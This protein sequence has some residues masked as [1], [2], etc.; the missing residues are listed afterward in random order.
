MIAR[1]QNL[2]RRQVSTTEAGIATVSNPFMI[3][4]NSS[5]SMMHGQVN[6]PNPSRMPGQLVAAVTG[7]NYLNGVVPPVRADSSNED[8]K[9]YPILWFLLSRLLPEEKQQ[10][11][12]QRLWLVNTQA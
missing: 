9:I 4:P 5:S 2:A 12:H 1:L 3:H 11:Y 7:S 10:P 8:T 6:Q